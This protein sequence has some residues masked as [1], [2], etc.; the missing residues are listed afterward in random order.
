MRLFTL[1]AIP[2][3]PSPS[4]VWADF[5]EFCTEFF[6]PD[7]ERFDIRLVLLSRDLKPSEQLKRVI[8]DP[9]SVDEI[10][11]EKGGLMWCPFSSIYPS[12]FVDVAT[13][14]PRLLSPSSP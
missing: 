8:D 2:P 9:T 3:F 10:V 7:H 1:I 11:G 14:E 5:A 4:H 12:K 13:R 6:H